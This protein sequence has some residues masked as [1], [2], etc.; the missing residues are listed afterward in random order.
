VRGLA[1]RSWRQFFASFAVK[2]NLTAKNAK[3]SQRTQSK[4]LGQGG[5]LSHHPELLFLAPRLWFC[6]DTRV[7]LLLA[8]LRSP[9]MLSKLFQCQD[10]G[11]FDGYRSR[12]RTFSEKYLLPLVLLRPVRCADCFRRSYRS[13]FVQA[14][15]RHSPE[16]TPRVAA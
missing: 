1:L 2:K 3:D 4:S 9:I 7:S 11:S 10:C 16:V 13:I 5:K 8:C 14:R 6:Y 15:E 12:S